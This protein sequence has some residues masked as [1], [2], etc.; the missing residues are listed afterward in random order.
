MKKILFV[1]LLFIVSVGFSQFKPQMK[2][3]LEE[4][5]N[6]FY[7]FFNT[8]L[9]IHDIDEQDTKYL[10]SLIAFADTNDYPIAKIYAFDIIAIKYR[11]E[12]KPNKA[13]EYHK[14]AIK[15]AHDI[16]NTEAEVVSLNMLGLCYRIMSDIPNAI[17]YHKKV[18]K[19]ASNIKTES[20]SHFTTIGIAM[21]SMGK[22]YMELKQYNYAIE[23]F[24]SGIKIHEK[25]NDVKGLAISYSS[26]GDAYAGLGKYDDALKFY[27]KA[28]EFN[29]TFNSNLGKILCYDRIANIYILKKE[30]TKAYD[31][32]ETIY[33]DA[34]ILNQPKYLAR[35]KV[36]LGRIQVAMDDLDAAESNLLE[37]YKIYK[38]LNIEYSRLSKLCV[39]ISEFY[40]KKKEFKKAYKF[41][42][43]GIQIA[44]KTLEKQNVLYIGSLIDRYET[45]SK[46]IRIK[47]LETE[48]KQK[49]FESSRIRTVLII[50]LITLAL[51]WVILFSVY[52]QGLLNND[53]K[54]LVL[55]QQAL[56]AQMN[57]HFVFNALNSIKLY[58]INNE[59]RQAVYYLNKFSKLIRNILDTSR[60][61]EVNLKEELETMDLYVTIENIRFNN[62]IEYKFQVDED[63]NLETIKIPP[64]LLQPFLENSIWHGLA[65]KKDNKKVTLIVNKGEAGKSVLITILDT[66]I[67]RE[68]AMKIKASKSLKRKSVGI[69]LTEQRLKNF[70]NNYIETCYIKYNDLKD[71]Q[72][73]VKGTSVVLKIPIF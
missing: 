7:K 53:K 57:P 67:G 14:K 62:E 58:I 11:D 21:N 69:D 25:I 15:L 50:I 5:P 42:K 56:Q 39:H 45:Q 24:S 17:D 63:L 44:E 28:L 54:V 30:Y 40:E 55:E 66:G 8:A 26:L 20:K 22:I 47:Q 51:L 73:N 6:S 16:N 2:R 70:S 61:K 27:K 32:L 72:G 46:K 31:T 12:R 64:L 59:Q 38:D 68:A 33:Y 29:K 35:I 52:R 41:Y 37:A 9:K 36:T 43:E 49:E 1:I 3:L 34:L 13:V 19:L 4:K 60:N 10:E 71:E 48:A 23:Q 65:S 18:L